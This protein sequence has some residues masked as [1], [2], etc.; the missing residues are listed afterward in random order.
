MGSN[1]SIADWRICTGIQAADKRGRARDEM[2]SKRQVRLGAGLR[3]APRDNSFDAPQ[4][5]WYDL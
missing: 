3:K 2:E 4:P 5:Q 1:C